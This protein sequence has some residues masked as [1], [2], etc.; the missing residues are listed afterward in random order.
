MTLYDERSIYV[1]KDAEAV[2]EHIETM[3][4]KFPTFAVLETRPFLF[5]R[6]ALVDGIRSAWKVITNRDFISEL[7]GKVMK[8]LEIGSSMG[9]FTLSVVERP[10]RYYFEIDSFFFSGE[11]GYRVVPAEGGCRVW[12]DCRSDGKRRIDRAWW[13]IIRP[14]HIFLAK[15]VLR[16]LKRDVESGRGASARV[17][18]QG[19]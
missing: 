15:K 4:S 3:P 13:R 7:H 11:T 18:P 16:A 17:T 5:V 2:F 14:I 9:P 1:E 10:D 12:F 19:S 8:R 6:L